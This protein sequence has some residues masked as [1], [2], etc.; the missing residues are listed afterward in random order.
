MRVLLVPNVGNPAAVTRA[1]EIATWLTGQDIEPVLEMSDAVACDLID[2]GVERFEIG[3][4]GLV[5]SLGGDG[6]ILKA[7][8]LIGENEVPLLGVN[9]GRLG[10]LT[11]AGPREARE[12]ITSALAGEVRI[13]HRATIRVRA[14]HETGMQEWRALNEVFVGR[15][16]VARVVGV[17]LRVDGVEVSRFRSDGLIVATATGSTAYAMSAGGPIVA[18]GFG[19]MV[20]VP[21]APHKLA[22]R[23]M[24]TDP[25]DTVE[26]AFDPARTDA[27]ITVDGR[28]VMCP[29][30]VLGLE[31]TR[32][33]VDVLL[34]RI[35][36][37]TFYRAVADEFFGA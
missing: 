28:Q 3:E 23:S 22:S 25:S 16:E 12:A 13:E 31:V 19:G 24:V 7:V 2:F 29:D 8:H 26:V 17:A 36:H 1:A 34:A 18:P 11:A 37:R 5:V 14:F 21:V 6:T 9:M 30:T 35:D 10:F 4:P 15:S 33:P 20:V 27:C 32:H